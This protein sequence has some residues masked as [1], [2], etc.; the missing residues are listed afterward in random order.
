MSQRKK[1]GRSLKIIFLKSPLHKIPVFFYKE[2][3]TEKLRVTDDLGHAEEG[4]P[5]AQKTAGL[6]L[7]LQMTAVINLLV[8]S[9]A[10]P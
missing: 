4:E 1:S 7:D 6:L 2:I 9:S 5:R 10:R 8:C 3:R